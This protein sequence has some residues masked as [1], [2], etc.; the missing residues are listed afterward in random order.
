MTP[1]APPPT[2]ATRTATGAPSRDPVAPPPRARARRSEVTRDRSRTTA[3]SRD[4][5]VKSTNVVDNSSVRNHPPTGRVQMPVQKNVREALGVRRCAVLNVLLERAGRGRASELATALPGGVVVRPRREDEEALGLDRHLAVRGR[6]SRRAPPTCG[7]RWRSSQP[8]EVEPP[9]RG[10]SAVV[11]GQPSRSCPDRRRR[12][13]PRRSSWSSSRALTPPWT[14]PG[15]PSYSAPR[16]TST[17]TC[18]SSSIVGGPRARKTRERVAQAGDGVAVVAHRPSVGT[19]ARRP[20]AR[21]GRLTRKAGGQRARSRR[22]PRPPR[23]RS[24]SVQQLGV[25]RSRVACGQ[26]GDD[27]VVLGE[28]LDAQVAGDGAWRGPCGQP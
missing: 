17:W 5:R 23:S 7:P 25:G 18:R 27:P 13:R 6:G 10:G 20:A 3:A 12:R 9:E 11:Q 16:S 21:C 1:E 15:G 26:G 4:E 28:L 24:T 8:L 2:T 22:S 14:S 19:R